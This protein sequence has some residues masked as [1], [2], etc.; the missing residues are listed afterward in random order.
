MHWEA[1]AIIPDV[2]KMGKE[3]KGFL[4][5]AVATLLLPISLAGQASDARGRGPPCR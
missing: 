4:L 3:I 1:T 5:I 2:Y